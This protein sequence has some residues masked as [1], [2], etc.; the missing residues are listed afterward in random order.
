MVL[1]IAKLGFADLLILFTFL[2]IS[3]G[4]SLI[5]SRK[6]K[7]QTGFFLGGRS[8]S[9]FMLGI[10]MV[11][12]TFA[13]DTPLAITEIVRENGISG[14]W[15]WWNAMLGGM[16]T[17]VFF[18]LFWRRSGV[19]TEVELIELRYSGKP[20][21]VLRKIK[22]I[23][24]G[25]L[26]NVMVM[27]W[28]NLAW[29]SILTYFFGLNENEVKW[30][31]LGNMLFV[32]FYV[33]IGGLKAV[34]RTDA[35]QFAL[36]MFGS[37]ILAYFVTKSPE[38]G[39]VRN[40]STHLPDETLKFVPSLRVGDSSFF[41]IGLTTLI[42][43]LGVVWW[44]S[45]YPGQEPGGGGY[46]VQRILS[47]KS[48]KD[49][50]LATLLFQIGHFCLRPWPWILVALCSIIIYPDLPKSEARFGYL[51]LIHDF[52]PNGWR[53]LMMAGFAGAYMSTISTQLN[54]GASYLINDFVPPEKTKKIGFKTLTISVMLLL[55][56]VS[57][58]LSFYIDSI[59]SVWQFILETGAGL[60]LVLILRWYWWRI[61][62]WSEIS[63]TFAPW[64]FFALSYFMLDL[65]FPNSLF[66]TVAATTFV[67]L[68]VTYLT[69]PEQQSTLKRFYQKVHPFGLWGGIGEK[70]GNRSLIFM[71]LAW[72]CGVIFIVSLLFLIGKILLQPTSSVLK[73][74]FSCGLSLLGLYFGLKQSKILR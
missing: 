20:A 39:G 16:F 6:N 37:I 25:F 50:V 45:W 61:N 69:K 73:Y 19:T 55:T 1:I 12:T 7:E 22:A 17:A 14:N 51:M 67:W 65:K 41:A 49:G 31:L 23:H 34:I 60:G 74:A 2:F 54:W 9:W 59:K 21:R 38:I 15:L 58:M 63:A 36:A 33:Q 29:S 42:A 53:G 13:A 35:L 30:A 26:M 72:I 18:A 27:A 66:F 70:P 46:V 64:V 43:Y 32:V 40:I 28:V 4:I 56:I 57:V 62:V 3:F 48:N 44:S 71:F 10:S 47:A 8:S 24:L 68:I 52:L 5:S 11:A